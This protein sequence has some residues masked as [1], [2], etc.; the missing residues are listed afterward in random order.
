MPTRAAY[1]VQR[2]LECVPAVLLVVM[3]VAPLVLLAFSPPLAYLLL[4]G[5]MLYW[6]VRTL[7]LVGRQWYE[8]FRIRRYR[9]LDWSARLRGLTDPYARLEEL[10][11]LARPSRSELEERDALIDWVKAGPDVPGPDDLY[12]LVVIP[13]A[14]EDGEIIEQ[15]LQSLLDTDFPDERLMVCLTFEGRSRVWTAPAIRRLVEPFA[16]RFGMLVTTQHPDG[17]PGEGRVKGAN[18]TWGAR[19]ARERLHERGIFD[20]H[21]VVSAF[22]CDTRPSRHYF[23]ALTYTYLT[24]PHRD[25]N[26]YQPI[27]MFHN[28]LWQASAVSRLVGY[29]ASMWTL[30]DSTQPRKLRLF[31]SHALGMKA[32]VHVD[33]WAVNVIPDD[34]RQYWRMYFATDGVARTRPL[35]TPV[36]LDAVQAEDFYSSMTEQYKQI[37]RWAY[38]VIDFPY[39]FTQSV[40]NTQIPGRSKYLQTFRQLAQFHQWALTP[41]LLMITNWVVG[42]ILPYAQTPEFN[43]VD[44]AQAGVAFTPW[45]TGLS[46]VAQILVALW[47]VPRPPEGRSRLAYLRLAIEW[48][49]LPVVV[50]VFF[51]LP[52]I[53]A[54]LRMAFGKYL[55]FRV[56]VKTRTAAASQIS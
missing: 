25:V 14:N 9:S 12:H 35:H 10:A 45:I 30:V 19:I 28:N 50:I 16:G 53:D 22:D 15:T 48:A 11:R 1:R 42:M 40:T 17:I 31:S 5:F 32:L 18:I 33:Y 34:S 21:V 43:L 29:V 27:L 49:L 55:G 24:D 51:C 46:L 7:G 3:I 56:T 47:M 20:E 39:V 38:G 4:T 36:Y 52:A 13:V 8:A 54:Q 2:A 23:A 41:L 26:S 44:V 37:R 6:A